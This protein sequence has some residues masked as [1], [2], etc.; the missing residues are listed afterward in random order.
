MFKVTNLMVEYFAY[1]EK[2]RGSNPLLLKYIYNYK[3]K[4]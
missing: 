2:V 1:N 4:I 3:K